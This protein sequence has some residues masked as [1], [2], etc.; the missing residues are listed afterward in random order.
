MSCIV[1]ATLKQALGIQHTAQDAWLQVVI[2]GVE[3]EVEDFL[4]FKLTNTSR[5]EGVDGGGYA[6]L[7]TGRPITSVTSVTDA[8]SGSLYSSGDYSLKDDG[9]WR[10]D[11]MRWAEGPPGRWTVEYVGG[12]TTV[13]SRVAAVLYDLAYRSVNAPGGQLGQSAAGYS[14]SWAGADNDIARRLAR[15]RCGSAVIG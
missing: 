9:I 3:D 14:V 7:P 13:P 2:D 15:Y 5:S 6:L 12:W 4:G 11:G 8:V 1:L 10:D